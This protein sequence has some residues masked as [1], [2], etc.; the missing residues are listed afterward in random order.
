MLVN[1]FAFSLVQFFRVTF[2]QHLVKDDLD[3]QFDIGAR[4]LLF[5]PIQNQLFMFK[6]LKNLFEKSET[7]LK[8]GYF[9]VN[10]LRTYWKKKKVA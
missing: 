4:L 3:S 6:S 10:D 8:K 5:A 1:G 2:R 7:V 9:G